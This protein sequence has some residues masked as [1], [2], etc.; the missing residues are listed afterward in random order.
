MALNESEHRLYVGARKP[1]MLIVLDTQ[2]GKTVTHLAATGFTDDASYDAAHK[3]IY[4]SGGDGFL[5]VYQEKD[6]ETYVQIAKIPT[7]EGARTSS[8]VPEQNRLYL[9]VP[10]VRPGDAAE[11]RIY[12]AN[13]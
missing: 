9:E 11:I 12:E 8:W 7:R 5:D 6:P 2:T 10:A 4:L 1:G 3:R 13:E